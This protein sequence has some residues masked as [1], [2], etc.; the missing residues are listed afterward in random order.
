MEYRYLTRAQAKN[1]TP[2]STYFMA[3]AFIIIMPILLQVKGKAGLAPIIFIT[4]F[5]LF[6]IC[7]LKIKDAIVSTRYIVDQQGFHLEDVIQRRGNFSKN[8]HYVGSFTWDEVKQIA[9]ISQTDSQS[10]CY[11]EFTF[12][13]NNTMQLAADKNGRDEL[14]YIPDTPDS[15]DLFSAIQQ[16]SGITIQQK[17]EFSK[18]V[19]VPEALIDIGK[20]P[21]GTYLSF[22]G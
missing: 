7:I 17:T 12:I 5:G 14:L 6:I 8:P 2:K 3:W 4:G 21:N 1:L 11:V 10:I 13:D 15:P 20:Y 9:R 22:F 18:P 16:L 19:P